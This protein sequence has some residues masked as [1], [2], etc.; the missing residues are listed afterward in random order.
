[1]SV[2]EFHQRADAVLQR[3]EQCMTEYDREKLKNFMYR[4]KQWGNVAEWQA[5]HLRKCEF[6]YN[7]E[8]LEEVRTYEATYAEQHLERFRLA[9]NYYRRE[10]YYSHIIGNVPEAFIQGTSDDYR[11]PYSDYLRMT[12]NKYFPK[13]WAAYADKPKFLAGSMVQVRSASA[14]PQRNPL[15]SRAGAQYGRG[16]GFRKLAGMHALVLDTSPFKPISAAKGGKPYKVLVVGNPEPMYIEE[17][18]LK[19]AKGVKR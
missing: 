8:F 18:F 17:R 16:W 15:S 14:L 3:A 5:E 4:S 6:S 10:G 9:C 7:D 11:P 19:R 2:E 13:I 12:D 1:M